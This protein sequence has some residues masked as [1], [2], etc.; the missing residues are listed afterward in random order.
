MNQNSESKTRILLIKTSGSIIINEMTATEE[1]LARQLTSDETRKEL[2]DGQQLRASRISNENTIAYGVTFDADLVK[3]T[4]SFHTYLRLFLLSSEKFDKH[5]ERIEERESSKFKR[6]IHN[7]R[8]LNAKI[9]QEVYC[10]ALQDRLIGNASR[11]I[12]YISSEV[13]R[14]PNASAKAFLSIL[15]CSAAQRA[16]FSAFEKMCG[17][18]DL[19]DKSMHSLHQVTMNVFYLFFSEF[20]DRNVKC[21]VQRSDLQGY[22]DY[23][24]MQVCFYH[25]VENASKYTKRGTPFDVYFQKKD[26]CID[27][28]FDMTSLYIHPGEIDE[29]FK[30]GYSGR[31]AV[32][33]KLN[34]SGFG[35]GISKQMAQLN[36]CTFKIINGSQ[37]NPHSN[38]ARNKFI[39]SIP[40]H[41]PAR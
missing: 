37:E 9:M 29:I 40:L 1:K 18:V 32:S 11:T 38:Y 24:S 7:L 17:N 22:F 15:K 30:E 21:T 3:S 39:V 19:I 26:N 4:K 34:G 33:C 20:S 23:E 27:I 35:L 13:E 28:I 25:L 31:E 8:T 5:L 2:I 41:N 36:G 16:E 12:Q 10:I 6:L 14:D